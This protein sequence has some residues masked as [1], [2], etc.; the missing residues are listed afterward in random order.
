M[1]YKVSTALYIRKSRQ[2]PEDET[3]EETLAR[4]TETLLALAKK[5]ELNVTGIYKEVVSGDGL[6][7]RPEMLRLLSDI[8]SGKYT[9]VVCMDI[10][11][12]GRSSQKDGGI[13]LETFKEN[14]IHIITPQKVYDLNDEIDETSVEMQSFLARQELKSINRRLRRG[15]VA[16]LK[17]GCHIGDIPYGYKRSYVGKRSTLAIVPEE[18]DIIK[19]VFDMYVHQHLGSHTIADRLNSMGYRTRENK[20]FSRSSVRAYLSNPVYTGKIVWNKMKHIKKKNVTDKHR[21]VPNPPEEWIVSEGIHPAL[22]SDELFAEAQRIRKTRSH[23][24]SYTGELKNP[25]SGLIYCA[26]CGTAMVRQSGKKF[27]PR[28][29]CPTANCNKSVVLDSLEEYILNFLRNVLDDLR[30]KQKT[31]K[32]DCNSRV[33]QIRTAMSD[34]KKELSALNKQKSSL[35][36]FLERGI[37]DTVTFLERSTILA[38]RIKATEATLADFKEEIKDIIN[39]PSYEDIIPT[40]THLLNDYATLSVAEKN[41][42]FKQIVRRIDYRREKHVWDNDFT[43]NILLTFEY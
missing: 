43:V 29:L 4:H 6:F 8:E 11:R 31:E 36:D 28:L 3:I 20:P 27:P 39:T 42:L 41:I 1:D 12:L 21:C 17:E 35:H 38:D 5:M 13:I 16:S 10:D 2:D 33:M 25:F 14:N 18:A 7:T 32:Q 19:L 22:I 24:P 23:P 30:N 9:A 15:M 34:A 26:N 40:L 37:Y